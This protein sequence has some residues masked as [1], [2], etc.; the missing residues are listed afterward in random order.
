MKPPKLMIVTTAYPYGKGES[1][2][3]A[4]L[5]HLSKYFSDIELVPCF[6]KAGAACRDSQH[7]VNLAYAAKRWGLFRKAYVLS[8]FVVALCRYQWRDELSRILHHQHRYE[9]LKELARSL[10][11]VSL[12]ENFLNKR[13]RNGAGEPDVI[14]FYWMIPEILGALGYRKS[15]NLP[16]K[17][18]SRAHGGDLYED[19]RKGHYSGLRESLVRDIDE[20]YCISDHG[21]CYLEKKYPIVTGKVHVARLGTTDTGYLNIQP[22]NDDLSIASCSFVVK[23]KRLHL[24][25]ETIQYMRKQN[26]VRKI[27][28]THIGDGELYE[29]LRAHVTDRVDA[30]TE[31]IFTGYLTNEQVMELYQQEQFDVFINVSDNEGIPVSL[32]EASSCG[33]PMIATNVGGNS[34]IV[35]SENGVLVSENPDIETIASALTRFADKPA[36]VKYRKQARTLWMKKFDA[37]VNHDAFGRH[38]AGTLRQSIDVTLQRE[39]NVGPQPMNRPDQSSTSAICIDTEFPGK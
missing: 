28:W 36:A 37:A 30:Q 5:E 12:F 18:I 13:G 20:I 2:L 22:G 8:S 19:Q 14:Y 38:L 15:R 27:K 17:I 9:N 35:N 16:L 1:F 39:I 4:E 10:Y 3:K 21:K 33:I 26:P 34:E 7:H 29:Q 6:H 31:V 11:R 25:F 23:G 24:I 32:M